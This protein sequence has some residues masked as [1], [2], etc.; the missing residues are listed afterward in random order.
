MLGRCA[1]TECL[2]GDD[3][4]I[5]VEAWTSCTKPVHHMCSNTVH[6]GDLDVRMCSE[7]CCVA[8]GLTKQ[9]SA[10]FAAYGT[11]Y[12]SGKHKRESARAD[13]KR[14]PAKKA[15]RK[16]N[17]TA[18]RAS[19]PPGAPGAPKSKQQRGSKTKVKQSQ[20][21]ELDGAPN[22]G[23]IGNGGIVERKT[24]PV[25]TIPNTKTNKKSTMQNDQVDAPR[26]T[27]SSQTE[28]GE[29]L[30][31]AVMSMRN[32]ESGLCSRS[33]CFSGDDDKLVTT[34]DEHCE[35]D[36][37][38]DEEGDDRL[39]KPKKFFFT[40]ADDLDLLL[41]V[42]GIQPYAAK[43]RSVTARYQDV[44]DH[45]N[46]H[47]GMELSLRTIKEHFFLLL[48]EFRTT[49][50]G[51]RKKSGVA[52]EYTEHKKYL[53]NTTDEM[54][55]LAA[56]KKKKKTDKEAKE[57]RPEMAGA[58]LREQAVARR[59][60]RADSSHRDEDDADDARTSESETLEPSND[61]TVAANGAANTTAPSS[62]S[63]TGTK[64]GPGITTAQ[65]N[66]ATVDFIERQRKRHDDEYSLL[67]EVLSF[68]R[69]MAEKEEARWK[70][71]CE[72]R[73]R[74]ADQNAKKWTEEVALRRSEMELRREE[75]AVLK[76]QLGIQL[77]PSAS[78]QFNVRFTLVRFLSK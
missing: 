77:L 37:D 15:A 58:K 18:K 41:E 43:H 47:W 67:R 62:T 76:H 51:Y 66:A 30:P 13:T 48:R 11:S 5:D 31:V 45:L 54:R 16:S 36:H 32:E 40:A 8:L 34:G 4:E 2:V 49:D 74:E 75:L 57:D 44:T 17:T 35:I 9:T 6:E 7:S 23:S 26:G 56:K 50:C 71:E 20:V 46:E 14:K 42:L 3:E 65:V 19:K 39:K 73:K 21:Q 72:F 22:R 52:V 10:A 29:T 60:R 38:S 27:A 25:A 33:E 69:A 78:T 64:A 1:F 28:R 12:T 70:E 55:D 63:S 61:P 59:C 24:R 53:Q 68:K